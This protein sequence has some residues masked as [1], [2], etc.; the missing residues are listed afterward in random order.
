MLQNGTILRGHYCIQE[1][2]GS[3]GFGITYLAVD[4][5]RLNHCK[6]VV[7]Q[8]SLR[9]HDPHTLPYASKLFEREAIVLERLGKKYDQIP[10][11]FAYFEENEEF[12][13]VQEFI[14]GKDLTS[15]IIPY[16]ALNENK[17]IALLQD[18]LEVLALVHQEN[19]IHRDIKP[20]NLIR[21]S[22]DKKIV[23]IDFGSVKEISTLE[24]NEDNTSGS[25]TRSIGTPGYI[26]IEQEEGRPELCSDIYA[27]GV[28]AIQAITGIP[29]RNL[30]KNSSGEIIW[31]KHA[32][33]V[34][35]SLAS[36]LNKMVCRNFENRY[37]SATEALIEL[38][39]ITKVVS[40]IP[41]TQLNGYRAYTKYIYR[42]PLITTIILSL[43]LSINAIFACWPIL[44]KIITDRANQNTNEVKIDLQD[45]CNSNLIYQDIP[46]AQLDG[47]ENIEKKGPYYEDE[48]TD[49][50][51]VFRWVCLYRLKPTP[52]NYPF[53]V[54]APKQHEIKRVGMNLDA[55][56]KMKYPDKYKA[57]HHDY[58]DPN[59]LKCVRPHPQ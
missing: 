29:P 39:Q 35:N 2:L 4:K 3:G 55:Y 19:V 6:L 5:D 58:N 21:R 49:V 56:C 42:Y 33:N 17:V 57:S 16:H 52:G 20:S 25:I 15:E 43:S 53:A 11:L 44:Q 23:L 31:R 59:S 40:A 22:S 34:S 1:R 32:P 7:K 27:L 54:P 51:P 28:L 36:F 50:W 14:D 13:L 48:Y 8:L 12:Y 24:V 30:E 41:P 45:V 38:T 46:E 37:Q 9:R 18:I 10:E 26:P 47:I